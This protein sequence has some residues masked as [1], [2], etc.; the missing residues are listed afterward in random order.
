MRSTEEDNRFT[1]V[2]RILQYSRNRNGFNKRFNFHL[3]LPDNL[4]LGSCI[5]IGHWP[6]FV[7][8]IKWLY[9]QKLN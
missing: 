4:G 3:F 2:D 9:D 1:A 8:L 5:R 7:L 6:L